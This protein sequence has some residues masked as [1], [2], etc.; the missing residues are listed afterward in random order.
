MRIP[1]LNTSESEFEDEFNALQ[2]R[3]AL[4]QGM[5]TEKQ[6]SVRETVQSIVD[7]VRR[8]GDEAVL[9]YT[10]RFDDV[11]LAPDRVRVSG[12]EIEAAAQAT[13]APLLGAMEKAA[14]R[15]QQFQEA[16]L[17]D[18]PPPVEDDGLSLRLRYGPVDAAGICV[19]GG[20]APLAS[21]VLMTV[22]PARVAGVERIV[23]ITK[24]GHQGTVSPERLAAARIAGVTEIYRVSGAQAVGALAYGT[25]SI[26]PVDMIA[27]PGNEYVTM[28]KKAVFGTVG[29]DMLA[30][31]SEVA[32][33]ADNGAPAAWV[34]AELLA[35]AEHHLG[36]AILVTDSET[37]AR[38][39]AERLEE[40]LPDLP[41][42]EEAENCLM[43]LGALIV[44]NDREECAR[45]VDRIAPEHLVIMTR[46]AEDDAR[47]IRHAGA[48]FLGNYTPVAA[49]D[50]IAGPSHCLPTG[51][52]ARFAGGLTANHFLK[53][54][55]LVRMSRGA[56]SADADAICRLAEA[57]Q[58]AAHARSVRTRLKD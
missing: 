32:V 34:A 40:Q 35:Q 15:I 4:A 47:N 39:A 28:A 3:R 29:I 33:M 48:I 31:P 57:E 20:A 2:E 24:P 56:L 26:D 46:D 9:E 37:L 14:E 7:D 55:S 16:I 27:G 21:T 45:I 17:L 11:R 5:E 42:R 1:F 43:E 54:S 13:P 51:C 49:G 41:R 19:P 18:D 36:S 44:T 12:A 38:E 58:L 22:I 25:G 50:Y 10:E 52:T 30:G 23:M 6:Q 53:N 8:R